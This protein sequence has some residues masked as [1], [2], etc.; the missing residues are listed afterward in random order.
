[1]ILEKTIVPCE[2]EQ[3][4]K[5]YYC[6]KFNSP[7][8]GI[9]ADGYLEVTSKRLLFQSRGEGIKGVS[10][11]QS[12]VAIGDVSEIKAYQGTSLNI[13]LLILGV[14][15]SWF[16]AGI[17]YLIFSKMINAGIGGFLAFVAFIFFVYRVYL[18]AQEK[19][20]SLIVNTK[21]NGGN[22][23]SIAGLSPFGGGNSAASK[24]KGL[25]ARPGKDSE[26][27]LRE[28]GAVVLDIQNMGEYGIEKWRK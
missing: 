19:T 24:G 22:V 16:A 2:G 3:L 26:V 1:M 7:L 4:V 8:F 11:I 15:I 18:W 17:V 23:V 20:F 5:S 13:G 10:I 14:I 9:K 21:G 25:S 12:E 27:M 6:T 28:L